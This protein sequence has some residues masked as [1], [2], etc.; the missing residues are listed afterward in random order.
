MKKALS[1]LAIICLLMG[2]TIFSV[3]ADETN[4]SITSVSYTS[5][6]NR[7]DL[8]IKGLAGKGAYV[9]ITVKNETG[10]VRA[11]EQC[12][13]EESGFFTK[14]VFVDTTDDLAL[15]NEDGAL[16][17]TVY[18]RDYYNSAASKTVLLYSE[19]IKQTIIDKNFKSTSDS[20]EMKAAIDKFGEVFGFNTTYYT[21]KDLEV[22]E[23]M[24]NEKQK[25][26]T[27]TIVDIFNESVIRAYL[28]DADLNA[29][30]TQILE[31]TDFGAVADFTN[32]FDNS[33]SLY[34]EYKAMTAEKKKAVN[35]IA[36]DKKNQ[37]ASFSKLKEIFFISIV[38]RT[39]EDN[40]NDYTAIF[41]F[42]KKH[43]DWLKLS[44]LE[45]LT[46]Y[47]ASQVIGLL[48]EKNIPDNREDFAKLY[49]D[50]V[51]EVN[52]ESKPVTP[53]PSGGK[54]S[55]SSGG[56]KT[57]ISSGVKLPVTENVPVI[58]ENNKYFTDLNGYTWADTAIKT[59]F[60]KKIVSG[61]SDIE[62]APGD[63]ITREEFAK[64]L[65][66]AYGLYD[67]SAE[68]EFSD[69]SKSDWSYRYIASIYKN[70][71]ASGYTDGSFGA[72]KNISREEMAVMIY[73][74]LVRQSKIKSPENVQSS[75]KDFDKISDFAVN[76]VLALKNDGI[77]S[78]DSDNNF[79]PQSNASRAETC[80]MIYNAAFAKEES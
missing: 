76:S 46:K 68:C 15:R 11:M 41:E 49:D 71:I 72:S 59:L 34:P 25:L 79:N 4:A 44:G 78:G 75:F 73:R 58:N 47:K 10:I 36:F 52:G 77:I 69:V 37:T 67:E 55:G 70:G 24:L 12:I 53:P 80:V 21:A 13:S 31:D 56:G 38:S 14:E 64:I 23:F 30:R 28:F 62:F 57:T 48:F 3:S 66:L 32:G 1:V 5:D 27:D 17:Y 8:L 6:D 18:V 19:N 51:S 29:D 42:L 45:K 60:D 26:N 9:S 40:K 61:R 35:E 39:F 16:S 50:C 22:A 65:T 74:V 43:N 7:F 20:G 2:M 63:S 33:S 54:D